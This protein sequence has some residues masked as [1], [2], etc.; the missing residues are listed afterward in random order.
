M[1]SPK[2]KIHTPDGEYVAS[3]KTPELAVQIA[4]LLGERARVRLH[5]KPVFAHIT[6]GDAFGESIDAAVRTLLEREA[7]L[8][9]R[10]AERHNTAP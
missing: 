3:C 8:Y 6:D 4:G 5:G 7:A 10:S 9:R 1:R 2:Y